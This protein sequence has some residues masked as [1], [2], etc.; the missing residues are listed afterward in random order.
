MSGTNSLPVHSI[1][2]S[3]IHSHTFPIP[4]V[5][6]EFYCIPFNPSPLSSSAPPISLIRSCFA[7]SMLKTRSGRY[8][9]DLVPPSHVTRS[10]L[11]ASFSS[12]RKFYQKSIYYVNIFDYP[13][14]RPPPP[15][16]PLNFSR[17]SA[18]WH[19]NFFLIIYGYEKITFFHFFFNQALPSPFRFEIAFVV[20][21]QFFGSFSTFP[22]F[23]LDF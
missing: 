4:Y 18:L 9:I 22:F 3:H 12:T 1:N 23:A 10:I 6:L 5:L 11:G 16:F 20:S 13:T 2:Y 14:L 15:T 17:A 19:L 21:K 8:S 7:C